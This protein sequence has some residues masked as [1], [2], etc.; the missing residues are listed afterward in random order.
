M[1]CWS[2]LELIDSEGVDSSISYMW[3]RNCNK[4]GWV[5]LLALP[6]LASF[7][8]C[9]YDN[10]ASTSAIA[11]KVSLIIHNHYASAISLVP[12]PFSYSVDHGITFH[13]DNKFSLPCQLA[14]LRGGGLADWCLLRFSDLPVLRTPPTHTSVGWSSMLEFHS[15]DPFFREIWYRCG[16]LV[17]RGW[18]PR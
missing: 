8:E 10:C 2:F 14:C 3:Y 9:W 4:W 1:Q 13:I 12:S 5:T 11:W 15:V 17:I 16:S 7:G 6:C 18:C